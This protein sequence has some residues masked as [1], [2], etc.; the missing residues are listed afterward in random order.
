MRLI[1]KHNSIV[2]AKSRKDWCY[3]HLLLPDLCT[4]DIVYNH[5]CACGFLPESQEKVDQDLDY[6]TRGD[7]IK[8][9]RIMGACKENKWL[10]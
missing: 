8:S 6:L 3:M 4:S 9:T 10:L 5:R 2:F 1:F 7:G